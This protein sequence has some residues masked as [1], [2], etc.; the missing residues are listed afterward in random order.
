[1]ASDK[2]SA[3]DFAVAGVVFSYIFNDAFAGG[4][5]WS[6]AAQAVVMASPKFCAWTM[7]MKNDLAGYLNTRKPSP[8]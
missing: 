7:R 1:M 6:A 8:M 2:I 5:K 3:A 4:A